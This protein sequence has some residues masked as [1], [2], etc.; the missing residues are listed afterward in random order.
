[1]DVT[2]A[3]L[4]YKT[5]VDTELEQYFARKV[6]ETES[7]SPEV[8]ELTEAI[9]EF[10]LR[11]GKRFRAALLYHAYRLCGGTREADII[12]LSAFIELIQTYLLIHDDI[13]DR[14]PLRRGG[15]TLHKKYEDFANKSALGDAVHFGQTMGILAGDI[16]SQMAWEIVSASPFPATRKV[17]LLK[18]MATEI[19]T[20]CIGQLHDISL[21]QSSDF[22]AAETIMAVYVQKTATYTFKL[23]LLAGAILAGAPI[24][25]LHALEGYA[26]PCGIAY[27]IR[28]DILDVFGQAD[29]TG[30]LGVDLTEGKRT[31][32]IAETHRRATKAQ[33]TILQAK[34]GRKDFSAQDAAVIRRI[35]TETGSLE[36]CSQTSIRCIADAQASLQSLLHRDKESFAFL[37]NLAAHLAVR[38]I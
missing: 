37:Q 31:L 8:K 26:I 33:R 27:Q 13:M 28:D 7:L 17:A 35:I 15:P 23:P 5:K 3:L 20:V 1:M 29:Q 25:N 4:E 9:A 18:L 11:G 38:T 21:S 22:P 6:V 34:L 2:S 30:K 14:S 24:R 36:H 12:R 32:L 16:A 19:H 10:T